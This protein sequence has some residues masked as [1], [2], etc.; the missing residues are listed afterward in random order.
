MVNIGY[1]GGY[2]YNVTKMLQRIEKF[3]KYTLKLG[4]Y[5]DYNCTLTVSGTK[6]V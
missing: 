1:T 4:I 2:T 3:L 6:L 5:T